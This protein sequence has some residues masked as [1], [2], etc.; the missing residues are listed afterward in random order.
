MVQGVKDE[1]EYG[2]EKTGE[3]LLHM[4]GREDRLLTPL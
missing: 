2:H 4:Q 3:V 1:H